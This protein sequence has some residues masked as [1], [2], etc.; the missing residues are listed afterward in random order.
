M[1]TDSV[2]DGLLES[3]KIALLLNWRLERGPVKGAGEYCKGLLVIDVLK[4]IDE[5]AKLAFAVGETERPSAAGGTRLEAG[6]VPRIPHRTR[7]QL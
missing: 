4:P 5:I 1:L 3:G 7:P 6:D 2:V